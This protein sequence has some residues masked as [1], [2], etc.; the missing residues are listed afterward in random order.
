MTKS[1][2]RNSTREHAH[3]LEYA[4]LVEN[5]YIIRTGVQSNLDPAAIALLNAFEETFF[6]FNHHFYSPA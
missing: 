6:L 1:L 5:A 3:G 4:R 2:Q